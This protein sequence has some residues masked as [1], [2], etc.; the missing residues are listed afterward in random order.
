[1]Y[2]AEWILSNDHLNYFLKFFD[3]DTPE[4]IKSNPVYK[5]EALLKF[6]N[7]DEVMQDWSCR[8]TQFKTQL[9]S[10]NFH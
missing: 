2:L 5:R 4:L 1:M 3:L 6:K 8:L 9:N 7:E 10:T